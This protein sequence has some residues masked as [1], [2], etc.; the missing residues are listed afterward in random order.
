MMKKIVVAILVLFLVG[1][2]NTL[3]NTN[4]EKMLNEASDELV[5]EDWQLELI[6][7]NV[8][9]KNYTNLINHRY[10]EV[11]DLEL[12]HLRILA[13]GDSFF[14]LDFTIPL[15]VKNAT[16]FHI[17]LVDCKENDDIVVECQLD[18]IDNIN[19]SVKSKSVKEPGKDSSSFALIVLREEITNDHVKWASEYVYIP[20]ENDSKIF[21]ETIDVPVLNEDVIKYQP[22]WDYHMASQSVEITD[23]PFDMI[24]ETDYSIIV[25][26]Y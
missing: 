13:Y 8:P 9:F 17:F 20:V 21:Y 26:I 19:S 5:L 1:C 7:E 24:S 12:D 16:G 15:E 10:F 23:N 3:G 4:S 6:N 11:K 22:I 14:S 2:Q 18:F 25:E